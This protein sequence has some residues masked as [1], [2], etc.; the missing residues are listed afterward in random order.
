VSQRRLSDQQR[1]ERRPRV[2]VVVGEHAHR[3]QLGVVEQV[4]LVE[5]DDRGAAPLGVLGGQR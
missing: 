5:D 3:L 1:R 2:H 4:R